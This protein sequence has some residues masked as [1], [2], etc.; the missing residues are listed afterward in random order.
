MIVSLSEGGG[1]RLDTDN[2]VETL[3]VPGNFL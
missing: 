3:K 1:E 2:T